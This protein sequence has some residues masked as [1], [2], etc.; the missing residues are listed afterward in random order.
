[1]SRGLGD[2]YK[3]Q[4]E[5]V[6]VIDQESTNGTY[7]NGKRLVPWERRKVLA[8]DRIAFS[9]VYYRVETGS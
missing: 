2:V 8:D 7:V 4:D 5:G 9:S 6:F 3:R 1:M